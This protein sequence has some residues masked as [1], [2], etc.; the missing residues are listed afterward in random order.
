M[1]LRFEN[2][3]H[4]YNSPSSEARKVLDIPKWTLAPGE[5]VL[6]RGVSGSGKTTLFNIAAGLLRPTSGN[7]W[8][9]DVS[10]YALQEA[11][12][13]R[14]RAKNI[15]YIFQTHYLLNTLTAI[16]NVVMPMAFS[17]TIPNSQWQDKATSL[18]RQVGLGDHLN[19]RPAQM[20]TG[21]RMR[22]AIAR[23]LVNTPRVLLADEPTASLDEEASNSAMDLI[24]K[25][26]EDTNATLIV[27]SH[28]PSLADRFNNVV[29]LKAGVLN[30][31]EVE[32]L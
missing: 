21:Q 32:R 22:V 24:Q 6:L 5:Q 8:Y 29:Y 3:T 7:I 2:L 9:D 27:A 25:T 18:L 13:D 10:I 31:P 16:E 12:R 26:C 14:F 20:S 30:V 1:T 23:A 28:D 17:K 11:I 19:Y 4:T 15:G